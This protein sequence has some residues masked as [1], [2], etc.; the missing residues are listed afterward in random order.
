MYTAVNFFKISSPSG[1]KTENILSSLGVITF[2]IIIISF[3]SLKNLLSC[4]KKKN[5]PKK[6]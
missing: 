3:I 1:G 5:F 2:L 6:Y 4:Q